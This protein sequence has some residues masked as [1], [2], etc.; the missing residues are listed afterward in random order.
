MQTNQVTKDQLTRWV[1]ALITTV[2]DCGSA[3]AGVL[4]AG[5]QT[6]GM[7]HDNFTHILGVLV[8]GGIIKVQSNIVTLT[9]EGRVKANELN[10]AIAKAKG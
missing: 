6:D 10:A 4:Y 8:Q 1:A 9:A 3:P 5:F 7:P 2:D